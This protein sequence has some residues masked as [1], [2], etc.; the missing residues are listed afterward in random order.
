MPSAKEILFF[1]PKKIYYFYLNF[2]FYK[3]WDYHETPSKKTMLLV[4]V[5][6]PHFVADTIT[7]F[8]F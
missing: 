7:Q 2:Y 8:N 3:L 5:T 1:L 6:L 4:L